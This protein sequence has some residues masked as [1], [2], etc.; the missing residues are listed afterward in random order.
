MQIN[1]V[2]T[3]VL[4]AAGVLWIQNAAANTNATPVISTTRL[5]AARDLQVVSEIERH[6]NIQDI[7]PEI[8][9]DA[10]FAMYRARQVCAEGHEREA[11][12][13]YEEILI[14]LLRAPGDRD[15]CSAALLEPPEDTTVLSIDIN[16]PAPL[17]HH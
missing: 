4:L 15:R 9:A 5:C 2:R 16:S 17:C 10:T 6:G 11:I 14:G 13:L 8:L 12:A 7:A 1:L 3:A